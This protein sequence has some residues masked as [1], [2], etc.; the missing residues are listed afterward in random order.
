MKRRFVSRLSSRCIASRRLGVIQAVVCLLAIPLFA[1]APAMAQSAPSSPEPAAATRPPANIRVLKMGK[2]IEREFGGR[3]KDSFQIPLAEG[4]YASLIIDH[5]ACDLTIRLLDTQGIEKIEADSHPGQVR[6]TFEFVAEKPGTYEI[7]L[8]PKYPKASAARYQISIGEIRAATAQDRALY[9]ARLQFS[10]ALRLYPTGAYDKAQSLAEHVLSLREKALGADHSDV[11]EALNLLG[12]ICTAQS[13]YNRADTLLQR[14]L[15]INKKAFGSDHPAVAEVTGNLAKNYNAKGNYAE[16]ER[17]AGNAL[18]IRQKVLG[19]DHFLVA[20]SLG[21]LGDI[22][23]AKGDYANA[24]RFSEQA[25][26]IA[27]AS[28]TADD[29]PY[30][31][32]SSLLARLEIKL[33]NYSSAEELLKNA[34]HARETVAGPDSLQAADSIYDLGYLYLIK[35]D[36]LKSEQMNLRALALK[37]KILGPDHLQLSLILHNLGLIHYRR[38]DYPTAETYYRRALAIKEKTLGPDHPLLAATVNNLGLM[39]WRQRDYDKA[40]KFYTRALEI[41]EKAYG[42]DSADTTFPLANL[43]IVAKETGDYDRAEAYYKRAL[44]IEEKIFGPENPRVGVTVE[45]LGILYRD[46]GDYAKAEPYFL[47]AVAITEKSLGPDHPDNAR[48]FRNL[49]RLYAAKGDLTSALKSLTRSNEIEEKNLPLNLAIGSERQKLAY[50]DPMAEDLERLISFQAQQDAADGAARDLAATT[51]IQRKGRVLDAMADNFGSL[52]RRSS[53]EDRALLDQL[54]SV[55]SQLAALVLKGPQGLSPAEYQ[56]RITKLT[57]QREQLETEVGRRSQG[58]YERSDTVTLSSIKA[59]IPA[60]AVLIEFAVYS[61]FD[62]KQAN[63]ST[64]SFG[65]PRYI[66]YIIPGQGDV[67]WKDLGAAKDIDA[68]VDAFR[69]SM[70]DPHR[71]NVKHVARALDKEIMQPLRDLIGNATHLLVSPD[72]QLD[73]IPFEALVDEKGQYLIER[74]SVTYLTTGRDLLRMQ[75]ARA[76]RSGPMVIADPAFGEPGFTELARAEPPRLGPR[77]ATTKRRS[78]TTAQDLS[79]VYFAPLTGTAREAR[80]I[81]AL[82]PETQVFTGAR[83]SKSVIRQIDAPSV[84]HIATHGFFLQ[85]TREN[86]SDKTKQPPA[87]SRSVRGSANV[88]NPLLRSGL[89][90]SGANLNKNSTEDGILT[91]L[92]ASN[93]NL[94]GTKLVTLSACDTGLGEVR[95]GEGVYGLRRAFFLSGAE[96]LVMSLWPVSDDVT[97]ET[98]TAYYTGL[99][100]GL[101]RGEALHQA[102]LAMMKRKGRQHPFYWAS[103]IQSGEWASLDGKK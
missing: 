38:G 37:E 32:A 13:N 11:A 98:M 14:A 44:A 102:E 59:A 30:A 60:D 53:P 6:D 93:L 57:Q 101:G 51:L 25:V 47:R 20:V 19:P 80:A 9:D 55:T 100:H 62:P 29:L 23:L 26:Q 8:E 17:L 27:A 35:N 12:V 79:G 56:A 84:L 65:D 42:V 87:D 28:Y 86:T 54:K 40:K 69:Q 71:Q 61:P 33:G 22:S 83:A 39:Y 67:R 88:E 18:D 96:T 75:V 91:A 90:L 48:H 94:W 36:N 97:R 15:A 103:F 3:E 82:F 76:S 72:G 1:Q 70:R 77:A 68:A 24:R 7:Q 46:K 95:N 85:D 2:P 21:T 89:A 58:Y 31:D 64:K 34:S 52:W 74:F 16:A 10:E 50:F 73:L 4:Q 78:I 5:R 43:G 45:S 49:E 41:C 66:A 99:K 81:Q 92:E 63:E